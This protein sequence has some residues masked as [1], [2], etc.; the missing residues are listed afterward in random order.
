ML[1]QTEQG[2]AFPAA[3][4]VGTKNLSGGMEVVTGLVQVSHFQ[5]NEPQPSERESDE[6]R[7]FGL[8]GVGYDAFIVGYGAFPS[9]AAP[10][11]VAQSENIGCLSESVAD[12]TGRLGSDTVDIFPFFL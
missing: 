1:T 8:L 4:S 11:G 2:H 12:D 3:Y 7:V 6:P 10:V 9:A 5:V